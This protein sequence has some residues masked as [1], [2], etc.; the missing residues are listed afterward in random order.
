M[1]DEKIWSGSAMGVSERCGAKDED[2]GGTIVR[3]STPWPGHVTPVLLMRSSAERRRSF[4]VHITADG[5]MFGRSHMHYAQVCSNRARSRELF[6][7]GVGIV[8]LNRDFLGLI[9][10][11]IHALNL[12]GQVRLQFSD[13]RNRGRCGDDPRCF[14]AGGQCPSRPRV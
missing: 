3:R 10:A 12:L 13:L 8:K 14:Q 4:I 1:K 2:C 7:S 6:M 9:V 11:I 5:Q